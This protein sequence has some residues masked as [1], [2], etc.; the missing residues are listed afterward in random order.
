MTVQGH[1]RSMIFI[2]IE[3]AYVTFNSNF[4]THFHRVSEIRI[5]VGGKSPFFLP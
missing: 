5:L 2:S 4:G 1:P 3:S